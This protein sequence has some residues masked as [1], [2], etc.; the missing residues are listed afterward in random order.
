MPPVG[1]D[2]VFAS[3]E[4]AYET[5]SA[6]LKAL[7]DPMVAVHSASSAYDPR[8]TGD[9][10]YKG[11]APITYS[12]S[13]AIWE[14]VEHPVVRTHPETGRKSLYVNPMF[15]Q[16]IV[17]LAAHESHALSRCS[18][19]RRGSSSHIGCAGRQAPSRCGTTA[20]CSTTR[21]ATA[22]RTRPVSR[23]ARRRAG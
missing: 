18:P 6:P 19:T 22:D 16:R 20:A 5:L 4:L 3:M 9:A 21:S 1:G 12:Y 8:T 23:D 13:D 14:E 15:T 17:G 2:T 7:L 11:E 10:K